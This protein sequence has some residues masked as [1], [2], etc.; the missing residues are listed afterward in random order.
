M[1]PLLAYKPSSQNQR[2]AG[3]EV[4]SDETPLIYR[5]ENISTYSDLQELLWAS[6]RQAFSE[7][8]IRE[9]S[10]TLPRVAI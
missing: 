4:A 5:R 1:L 6:Y 3:Y 8:E 10:P 9:L 2:V 7:H